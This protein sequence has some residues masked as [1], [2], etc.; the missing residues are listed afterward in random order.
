MAPPRLADPVATCRRRTTRG[1]VLDAV[2]LALCGCGVGAAFGFG[3][4]LANDV[5]GMAGYAIVLAGALLGFALARIHIEM[6]FGIS[7]TLAVVVVV[8]TGASRLLAG[9][10]EGFDSVTSGLLTGMGLWLMT[11]IVR[12]H[13]D[14]VGGRRRWHAGGL[15]AVAA[16]LG[17]TVTIIS[18]AGNGNADGSLM[19]ATAIIT[20]T[21]GGMALI[22]LGADRCVGQLSGSRAGRY[23]RRMT[24]GSAECRERMGHPAR[25]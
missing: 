7:G 11:R 23:A 3:G 18:Q 1:V 6:F 5:G 4:G 10:F 24:A 19:W 21:A 9:V 20:V 17:L 8:C 14:R 15:V 22:R 12:R 25:S 13:V 2:G 16:A